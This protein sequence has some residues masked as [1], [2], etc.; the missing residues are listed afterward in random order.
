MEGKIISRRSF[1][2]HAAKLSLPVAIAT[3]AGY[4]LEA[5]DSPFVNPSM[6]PNCQTIG[7]IEGSTS[8][9]SAAYVTGKLNNETI[10]NSINLEPKYVNNA[11]FS[12]GACVFINGASMFRLTDTEGGSMFLVV[13]H[14]LSSQVTKHMDKSVIVGGIYWSAVE[15]QS[16]AISN[17]LA[18]SCMLDSLPELTTYECILAVNAIY[19]SKWNLLESINTGNSMFGSAP[20]AEQ[21]RMHTSNRVAS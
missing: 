5:C 17:G 10:Y 15:S 12:N 16:N 8:N 2:K 14:Q 19:D 4:L 21:Q 7:Q 11:T 1:L 3:A 6:K 18:G 13:P 9:G 20:Q